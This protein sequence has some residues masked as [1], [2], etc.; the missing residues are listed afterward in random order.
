MPC[1]ALSLLFALALM[2]V[3]ARAADTAGGEAGRN[4]EIGG[5]V[6][7]DHQSRVA[8]DANPALA[9]GEVA[10]GA[11]VTL[12]EDIL[13]SVVLMAEEDLEKIFFD[14]AMAQVTP[15]GGPWTLLFGQQTVG[16]GLLSTR[17][18]SDPEILPYLEI[19]RPALWANYARGEFLA[20][21]GLV[22]WET[23]EGDSASRDYAWLPALDWHHGPVQARLS[24]MF[25]RYLSDADA[26]V[27]VAWGRLT[28]DAEGFARLPAWDGRESTAGYLLG[29][30]CSLG[31][32]VSVAFRHD[33]VGDADTRRLDILRNGLGFT[34][35]L[36]QDLFA[37]AEFSDGRGGDNPGRRLAL[38]LG[39]KSSL[40]LPGFQRATLTQD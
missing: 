25:S 16:H 30:E 8:S 13:A 22:L 23:G 35:T 34:F 19:N 3:P 38:Q 12:T 32:R 15:A 28:F 18:I 4:L 14:Q 40:N 39:L 26:A 6:T 11:N 37:A 33:G 7:L 17:L 36:K 29:V 2:S 27:T 9:L 1:T 21:G 10:L 20:G 24:G 31:K 5:L